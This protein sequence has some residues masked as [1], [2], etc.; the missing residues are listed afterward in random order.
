MGISR[1]QFWDTSKNGKAMLLMIAENKEVELVKDICEWLVDQRELGIR[2]ELLASKKLSPDSCK[3][4][5]QDAVASV[6]RN[7]EAI[8]D[9]NV[10]AACQSVVDDLFLRFYKQG[11]QVYEKVMAELANTLR[12]KVV[13]DK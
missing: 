12:K 11:P 8:N 13:D 10:V 9:R 4:K 1:N 2:N 6:R 3:L 7:A 5:A